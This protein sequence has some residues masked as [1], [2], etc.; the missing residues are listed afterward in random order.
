M[1]LF[2]NFTIMMEADADNGMSAA[3]KTRSDLTYLA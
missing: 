2:E 3:W 1:L